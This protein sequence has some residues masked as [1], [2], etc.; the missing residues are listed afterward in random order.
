MLFLHETYLNRQFVY[1]FFNRFIE[2]L[3]LLQS[4]GILL[5]RDNQTGFRHLFKRLVDACDV[6]T[7]EAMVI[8][9]TQRLHTLDHRL[10]VVFHLL[11]RCNASNQQ[12]MI[13]LQFFLCYLLVF[14]YALWCIIVNAGEVE[15]L[16]RV[17]VHGLGEYTEFHRLQVL[18]TFGDNHNV[19][20]VLAAQRFSQS[21]G[22][23]HL[24]IDN[25]SVIIYQQDVDAWLYIA[26]LEGIIQ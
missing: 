18:W 20:T 25:Q 4:H 14:E 8:T 13:V 21:S 10:Q 22:R 3:R 15:L 12:Y 26:M 24:V 23:Q 17:E 19:G 5:C 7:L 11:R 1:A 2:T 6:L 16:E 9:E